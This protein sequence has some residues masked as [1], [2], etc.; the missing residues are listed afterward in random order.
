MTSDQLNAFVNALSTDKALQDKIKAATDAAVL[1]IAKD[2]GYSF[3]L[4]TCEAASTDLSD[5]QLESVTG[6]KWGN[7][8]GGVV[9]GGVNALVTTL[10]VKYM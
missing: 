3:T 6:G 8:A 1:A 10:M 7:F 9:G 2:A 4:E 5:A